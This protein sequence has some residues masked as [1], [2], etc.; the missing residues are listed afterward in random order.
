MFVH[1]PKTLAQLCSSQ[2]YSQL[3][4]LGNKL[5]VPQPKTD[6]ENV[7]HLHNR[8]LL[9]GKRNDIMKFA[10]KY[11]ELVKKKNLV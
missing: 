10:V 3:R 2:N 4:E 5:D 1:T 7:I 6:K 11:I 9:T 8:L